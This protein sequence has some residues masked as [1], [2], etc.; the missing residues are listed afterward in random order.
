ME[1]KVLMLARPNLF[2]YPGGDTTQ[3]VKTAEALRKS[4]L[5]IDVN[6]PKPINYDDYDLLH[7]FNIIDPEDILGPINRC[8]KPFVL[9]TVYCLYEEYDRYHRS[10]FASL[11]YSVFSKNGVEYLKTVAKWLLKRDPISSY[12]F[13]W[14]GH[15]GSIQKILRKSACLLPNSESE[16]QRVLADFGIEKPYVVVP[17]GVDLKTYAPTPV[18]DRDLVICVGRIEGRKNQLNLIKAMNDTGIPLYIVGLP[19]KNQPG[20][21]RKCR[22]MADSNI[23][24]TGYVAQEAL[25]QYYGRAKVH[26]LPSWFETTGLSSLEAALMGCNTVVSERGD[27]REYFQKDAWYCDPNHPDSI[28][29]AVLEAFS[30]PYNPALAKRI[31][32]EYHWEK[33]A[34]KTLEG[35]RIALMKGEL[36]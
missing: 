4:G 10:S 24:F 33:A 9:S 18:K 12:E 11:I 30:A 28:K 13:F 20:Y 2:S 36:K 31:G 27:V 7:F 19:A 29:R 1:I 14:R 32:A 3:I 8:A 22:Q 26:V 15:K 5:R 6:P 34:E 21:Y 23:H 35:Y 16:Y 17:N 25:L